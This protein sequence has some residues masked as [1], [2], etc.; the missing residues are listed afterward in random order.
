MRYYFEAM[1]IIL[2]LVYIAMAA[3]HFI[4]RGKGIDH[5]SYD[6][7]QLIHRDKAFKFAFLTLIPALVLCEALEGKGIVWCENGMDTFIAMVLSLVVFMAYCIYTDA[8]FGVAQRPGECI[9]ALV[10]V[11]AFWL[12][13]EVY[14]LTVGK[15][16]AAELLSAEHSKFVLGL[17]A[18][19]TLINVII[20]LMIDRCGEEKE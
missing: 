20:K 15:T 12:A 4:R 3:A 7:R 10:I 13:P 16:A 11:S 9:A 18:L 19:V 5:E 8:Y 17:A 2:P 6:E 1:L 14:G